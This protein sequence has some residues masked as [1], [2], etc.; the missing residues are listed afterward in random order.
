MEKAKYS[1]VLPFIGSALAWAAFSC[2]VLCKFSSPVGHPW[3]VTFRW[4]FQL[5]FLSLVDL[6]ALAKVSS[7]VLAG[8]PEESKN[9][10][11]MLFRASYWGFLKLAC[12]GIFLFVLIKGQAIPALSLVTGLGTLIVVPLVG[13]IW[14]SQRTVSH[15]W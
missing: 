9:R 11:Q 6:I 2:V 15:A 10:A 7:I 3:V 8:V 1:F 14:W 4:F 5:W 13:G 12:L